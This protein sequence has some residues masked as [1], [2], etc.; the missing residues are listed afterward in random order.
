MLVNGLTKE[1][2]KTEMRPFKKEFFIRYIT[3]DRLG[4]ST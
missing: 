4:S 2:N 3:R 1:L